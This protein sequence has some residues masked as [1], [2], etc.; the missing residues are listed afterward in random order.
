V[1]SFQSV[2]SFLAVAKVAY[3]VDYQMLGQ[4]WVLNAATVSLS[5]NQL[6][7]EVTEPPRRTL[8]IL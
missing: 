1:K 8:L 7:I 5:S 4:N 2:G 6:E 3:R